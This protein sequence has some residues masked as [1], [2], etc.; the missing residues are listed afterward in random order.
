MNKA[1]LLMGGNVGDT[2]NNLQQAIELL[3]KEC[4]TIVQ[5]SS[6]YETAPWGKTDQQDFLNQAV[7][8]VT[9][10]SAQELMHHILL[11]EEK[12][13]RRRIEK[14]GPRVIDIDILF[15]NGAIIRDPQLTIPHPE[16]Q[17]RRFALVPLVEIAPDMSHP[18]LD[19]TI[20]ELLMN[21]PDH[22]E[23]SLFA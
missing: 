2:M 21:C 1:Y 5:K 20:T 23:V 11:I 10:L 18:V 3:N 6:V 16:L 14:Y 4:G 19:K 13:G 22:L 17:Y 7:L 15:F 12:L 9:N 8:L